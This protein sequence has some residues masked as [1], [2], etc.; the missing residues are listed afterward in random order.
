MGGGRPVVDRRSET[1]QPLEL[2]APGTEW[3]AHSFGGRGR[4][5]GVAIGVADGQPPGVRKTPGRL[6]Y[7]PH[8]WT[9]AQWGAAAIPA[10]PRDPG[11]R[12]DRHGARADAI[13]RRAAAA[14]Q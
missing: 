6:E 13:T 9:W 12:I 7:L 4:G 3:D 1:R 8:R 14:V 2:M 10:V 5:R 11:H